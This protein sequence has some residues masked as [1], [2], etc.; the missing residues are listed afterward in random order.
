VQADS[1]SDSDSENR[2]KN[3]EII[4]VNRLTPTVCTDPPE[5]ATTI[6]IWTVK[7]RT[8]F[9]PTGADSR[10]RSRS[11]NL[12]ALYALCRLSE[13]ESEPESA[14]TIRFAP[15]LGIGVG[16]WICLHYMLCANWRQLSG[17]ES[18]PE[19]ACPIRV[20]L[21]YL[22]NVDTALAYDK[23]NSCCQWKSIKF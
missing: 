3:E 6:R 21:D 7:Q 12:P 16:A 10:N 1:G 17:S 5:P 2:N 18:E 9:A 8:F 13:S 20:P 23:T 11:L 19:S 22:E 4:P 14:C 15:T